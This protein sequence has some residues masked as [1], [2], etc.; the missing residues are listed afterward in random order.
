MNERK[1]E[2][3][4]Q[5]EGRVNKGWMKERKRRK[6][7]RKEGRKEGRKNKGWMKERKR[8]NTEGRKEGR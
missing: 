1:E 6:N 7:W 8:R 5:K 4:E 2:N 3:K